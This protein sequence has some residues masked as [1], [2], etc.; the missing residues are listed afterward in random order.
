MV[1]LNRREILG[2][3]AVLAATGLPAYAD[4]AHLQYLGLA[5]PA[6]TIETPELNV[7]DLAGKIHQVKDYEGKTVLVSFWATWCPPCRKEMPT[8]ARLSRELG[9]DDFAVLAVNV[10]DKQEKIQAFLDEIDH[11]G[12]PVLM[13][14][15]TDL[16]GKWF[17]RGLPVTY[18][19]TP[20]GQV[21]YGAIGERVWD[22]PAMISGIRS[23][24]DAS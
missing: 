5:K 4:N 21:A 23:I 16:P 14:Q 7:P 19:L 17:L 3:C 9:T 20:D 2:A 18:V 11:D 8:L 1:N 10:G 12:L 13:D 6:L 22:S 15:K 24:H